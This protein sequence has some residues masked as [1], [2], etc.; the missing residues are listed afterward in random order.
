[1]GKV[2]EILI[3]L[4][5]VILILLG[6]F[7]FIS[8]FLKWLFDSI[9][10]IVFIDNAETGLPMAAEYIIKGITEAV[11]LSIALVLGISQK[12]PLITICSIILGFV[13]CIIIYALCK[14]IIAIMI[15]LIIALAILIIFNIIKKKKKNKDELLE[16]KE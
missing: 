7:S 6:F 13:V 15:L 16:V 4:V 5:V 9:N 14:Y 2:K 10:W 8:E 1:M 3:G 12:S 11:I